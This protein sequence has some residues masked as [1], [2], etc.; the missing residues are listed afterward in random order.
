MQECYYLLCT[1]TLGSELIEVV[2]DDDASGNKLPGDIFKKIFENYGF[3]VQFEESAKRRLSFYGGR[4]NDEGVRAEF[5]QCC[6]TTID[7]FGV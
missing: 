5:L 6:A 3:R 7:R 1:N 2:G 4:I